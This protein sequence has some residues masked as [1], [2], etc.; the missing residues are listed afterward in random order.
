MK[1][2]F[3]QINGVYF[4]Q[5][6]KIEFIYFSKQQWSYFAYNQNSF[7]KLNTFLFSYTKLIVQNKFCWSMNIYHSNPSK[8]N[9]AYWTR[10]NALGIWLNAL[11]GPYINLI[12]PALRCSEHKKRNKSRIHGEVHK[13]FSELKGAP[14]K[15]KSSNAGQCKTWSASAIMR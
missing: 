15:S 4:L 5:N 12:R 13:G 9:E 1:I 6:Y 7:I 2:K 8:K 14:K 11:S 10:Q 3:C